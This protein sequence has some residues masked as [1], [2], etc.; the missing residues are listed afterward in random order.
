MMPPGGIK[1]STDAKDYLKYVD[2]NAV[3]IS[4]AWTAGPFEMQSVG[5]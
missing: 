2:P 1:V 4:T 5:P 3:P